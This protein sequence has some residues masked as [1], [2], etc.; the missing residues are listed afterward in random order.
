MFFASV[1]TGA[2]VCGIADLTTII[3]AVLGWETVTNTV[4]ATLGTAT[5]TD[6]S[7][8]RERNETLGRQGAATAV[9]IFSPIA[10]RTSRRGPRSDSRM[11]SAA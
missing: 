11:T 8:R 9:A 10:S 2:I 4:A 1:E 3:S 5:Q 7:A 6:V